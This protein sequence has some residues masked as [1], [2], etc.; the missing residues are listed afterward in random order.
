MSRQTLI[1]RVLEQRA[2]DSYEG[3]APVVSVEE[4]FDG[5]D[6]LGSIGCNLDDHPGVAVFRSVLDAVKLR[7]EVQE[8]LIE[9]S[10]VEPGDESMWPF[11]ERVYV[12]TTASPAEVSAWLNQLEP[13]EVAEGWFQGAP[14]AAPALSPGFRP[15]A[16]WWD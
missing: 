10:E 5:N 16:A 12:L 7:D 2:L 4:F 11:S 3:P 15:I 6:D 14:P 1:D 13:S 9:V 8:V